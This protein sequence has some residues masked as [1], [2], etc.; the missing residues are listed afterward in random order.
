[1]STDT[2]TTESTGLAAER[3]ERILEILK[4]RHVIRVDELGRSLGV[5]PATVRRDLEELDHRGQVQRVHGGAVRVEG[6]LDEPGFEDKAA[7]SAREKQ[8]IAEAALAYVKPGDSIFLDGGSTILGLARLVA[9]MSRLTVVT[10]SLRVAAT[11]AGGG[12]RTI[13]T[14]GE[15]RRLSQTFV[16]ALSRPLIEQL[17]VDTAFMGTIGLSVAEELTTTDPGEAQTKSLVIAQSRQVVLLA[18]S[19]KIGKASFVKFAALKEIDAFITDSRA[20]A[21][22]VRELKKSGMNVITV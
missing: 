9:T 20:Q 4:E 12:P 18:D 10:N 5:S 21:R 3:A 17:H 7:Q 22:D 2:I 8:R 11:L 16:G 1:M 13:L 15:L 19:T 6:S 14:G